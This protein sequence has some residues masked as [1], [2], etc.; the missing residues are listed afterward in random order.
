MRKINQHEKHSLKKGGGGGS[1]FKTV[2]VIKDSL[3]KYFILKKTQQ[4]RQ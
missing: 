2:T 4:T 3:W 1:T